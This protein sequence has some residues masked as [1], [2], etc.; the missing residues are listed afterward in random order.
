MAST[1]YRLYRGVGG[2]GSVDFSS[3]VDTCG[4]G[5][6]V[7]QTVGLGHVASTT[8]T[9]VLRPVKSDLITPDYSCA[10]EFVT[11][12]DGDWLGNRP[13][14]ATGLSAEAIGGAELRL[15]WHYITPR[16]GSAPSDFG[17]Y[18]G[19]EYPVDTSGAPDTTESYT[20]DGFYTKDVSLVD[21]TTYYIAV[22][23]RTAGGV[24]SVAISTGPVVADGTAP[25]APTI[26]TEADF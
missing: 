15:R 20:R 7:I 12:S 8:Y 19:S 18:H 6:V 4:S 9:Y 24:E 3:A 21:A 22:T 25:G 23:A 16:G 14:P 10:V 1:E 13:T 26:Y 5:E 2:I 17:I 11:D